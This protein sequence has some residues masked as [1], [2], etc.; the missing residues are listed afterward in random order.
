[1]RAR[2]IFNLGDAPAVLVWGGGFGIAHGMLDMADAFR[3]LDVNA[4]PIFVTG[5]NR[6]LAARVARRAPSHARV[7]T[8]VEDVPMLL[9]AVDVVMGKPGWVSL[10][11]ARSAGLHTICF[12]SLPGQEA[13]NLRVAVRDGSASWQPDIRLAVQ[14]ISAALSTSRTLERVPPSA[15]SPTTVAAIFGADREL[16]A[17]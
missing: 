8:Y 6:R 13:E 7:M 11:E 10:V 16:I 12:D 2:Q 3:A 15:L 14:A 9:S 17:R 1:M 5:T 4:V